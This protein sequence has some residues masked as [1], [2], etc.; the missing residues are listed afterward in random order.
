MYTR[1]GN[2]HKSQR[3]GSFETEYPSGF[4]QLFPTLQA[5]SAAIQQQQ[6]QQQQTELARI[7]AEQ[8]SEAAKFQFATGLTSSLLNAGSSI[9]AALITR[10][11]RRR[12]PA[13]APAPVQF[14]PQ[15]VAQDVAQNRTTWILGLGIVGALL[16]GLVY[17]NKQS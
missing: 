8:Q 13:P 12:Q 16:L 17:I 1:L 14:L 3:L 10:D 9:A 15:V 7:Q 4:G 6:Q 5:G 2:L 11:D